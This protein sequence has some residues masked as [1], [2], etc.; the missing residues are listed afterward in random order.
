V[1]ADCEVV[2][3]RPEFEAPPQPEPETNTTAE[4]NVTD[5]V[6]SESN[7]TDGATAGM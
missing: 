3:E 6:A 5:T 7:D 2:E 1:I 4:S